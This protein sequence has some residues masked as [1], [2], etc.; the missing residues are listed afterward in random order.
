MASLAVVEVDTTT[1]VFTIRPAVQADIDAVVTPTVSA[2]VDSKI[3]SAEQRVWQKMVEAD[4]NTAT[5]VE[6]TLMGKIKAA[7]QAAVDYFS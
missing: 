4:V 6:T 3:V 2:Q 5:N 7:L 1:G